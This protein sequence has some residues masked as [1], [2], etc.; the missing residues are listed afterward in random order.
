[1]VFLLLPETSNVPLEGI[2]QLYRTHWLWRHFSRTSSSSGKRQRKQQGAHKQQQQQQQQEQQ[3]EQQLAPGSFKQ[4]H[5][6]RGTA[7][8][9]S[10][11]RLR[12]ASAPVAAVPQPSTATAAAASAGQGSSSS[13]GDK[14]QP[15]PAPPPQ[16]QQEEARAT[17][18][19]FLAR[20]ASVL[21]LL[22]PRSLL[23]PQRQQQQEQQ[24]Q[25]QPPDSQEQQLWGPPLNERGSTGHTVSASLDLAAFKYGQPGTS[26][27]RRGSGGG[28]A[29]SGGGDANRE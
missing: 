20:P 24:Q 28:G 4:Q 14:M 29:S 13:S 17:F 21:G 16:Q 18:G 3:Q 27:W 23:A 5:Q 6:S 22:R 8:G 12:H 11:A 26:S 25:E 10:V 19:S 15:P 7:R 2:A 1:V 9:P